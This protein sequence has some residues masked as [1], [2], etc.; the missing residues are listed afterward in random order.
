MGDMPFAKN[1]VIS[2]AS[3]GILII[4]AISSLGVY[5]IIMSGW[6][7]IQNMLF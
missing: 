6:S 1:I 4:F 2:D 3:L 7:S 5:G